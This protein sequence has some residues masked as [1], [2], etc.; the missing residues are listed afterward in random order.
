MGTGKTS[1]GRLLAWRLGRLFVDIDD[2]IEQ[3][4]GQKIREIFA[5]QGEDF[6]RRLERDAIAQVSRYTNAVIATGGG[7]V[8]NGENIKRLR[9]NG[10]L[11]ALT[12]T[13]DDILART[14]G[15][16][17]RPLLL[18]DDLRAVVEKLLARRA[19]LYAQA[20][21]SLDTSG[22]T[23]QEVCDRIIKLLRTGGYL[24]GRS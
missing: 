10:V 2:R 16:G 19:P 3:A 24:C 11:I 12:A 1:T 17:T 8:E 13:V 21:F 5:T 23:P 14:A 4:A 20:E 18:H 6:F 7:A 22:C 15:R 9:R